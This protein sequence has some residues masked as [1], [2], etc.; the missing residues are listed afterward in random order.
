MRQNVLDNG[1]EEMGKEG[2]R[3]ENHQK[4]PVF[5]SRSSKF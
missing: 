3:A 4:I 5:I 2:T 1:D